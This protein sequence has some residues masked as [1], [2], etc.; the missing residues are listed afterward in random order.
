[1]FDRITK[2]LDRR[3]MAAAGSEAELDARPPSN[4]VAEP[5]VD[6][7]PQHRPQDIAAFTERLRVIDA[8]PYLCLV[9]DA[10]RLVSVFDDLKYDRADLDAL[11]GPMR[12]RIATK[13]KPLGFQQVSGSVLENRDRDIRMI[14]PKFRALG[15]SPFDATRDSPR[16]DQDYY[17]L[18]PTQAACQVIDAY[19]IHDAI[20][21]IET[22]IAKHPINLLRIFDYLDKSDRHRA[23]AGALHH[24]GELQRKAVASEPLRRRRA[25]R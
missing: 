3:R 1:M 20:D 18:T 24:L 15:A 19:Q 16:R 8:D 9:D 17:I 11:S 12:A 21:R 22:L 13:L 23:F 25:L 5:H 4:P 7:T 14:L 6:D 10:L 2:L